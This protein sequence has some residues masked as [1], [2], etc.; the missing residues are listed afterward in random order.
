MCECLCDVS[1]NQIVCEKKLRGGEN[2]HS[3]NIKNLQNS[4]NFQKC[5]PPTQYHV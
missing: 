4:K 1:V 5:P 3:N 2:T